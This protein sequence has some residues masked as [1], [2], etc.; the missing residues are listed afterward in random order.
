VLVDAANAFQRRVFEDSGVQ[1]VGIGRGT[2][3]PPMDLCRIVYD[4][5][6]VVER[7]LASEAA[8]LITTFNATSASHDFARV[9]FE[10]VQYLAGTCPTGCAIADPGLAASALDH[11]DFASRLVAKAIAASKS[12]Y[13]AA[14]RHP[15]SRAIDFRVH[16]S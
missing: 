7:G 2:R 11:G 13:A 6:R 9:R 8:A 15:S 5:F 12:A 1:Y 4:A 10:Q 16:L 14:Q 3:E